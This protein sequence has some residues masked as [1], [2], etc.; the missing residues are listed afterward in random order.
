MSTAREPQAVYGPHIPPMLLWQRLGEPG[1]PFHWPG[2]PLPD[3]IAYPKVG[4]QFTL[5]FAQTEP[6]DGLECGE[7]EGET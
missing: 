1:F 4:E 6:R 2:G 5:I 3:T 7:G